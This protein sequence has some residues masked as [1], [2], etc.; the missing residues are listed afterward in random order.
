MIYSQLPEFIIAREKYSMPLGLLYLSAYLQYNSKHK[1]EVLDCSKEDSASVLKIRDFLSFYKPDLIGIT[2]YTVNWIDMIS[3]AKLIKDILPQIHVVLGGVHA[4]MFPRE[5]LSFSCIDSVI[6]GEGEE[7]LLELCDALEEKADLSGI[8]GLITKDKIDID[9]SDETRLIENLDSLPFPDRS[10]VIKLDKSYLKF[11]NSVKS[12]AFIISSRGCPFNCAFCSNFPKVYRLRSVKNIV[13]EMEECKHQGFNYLIFYDETFNIT[14]SRVIE[15]SEEILNRNL[16]I[17]WSFRARVNNIEE[18][19]LFLAKRAGC[20]AINY[21]VETST[22]EGLCILNKGI[23]IEEAKRAFYLTRKTRILSLAYFMIG[24]PHE[25]THNDIAKTINFARKLK[26]DYAIFSILTLFP[27]TKLYDLAVERG[28]F[29]DDIWKNFVL[30][31]FENFSPPVWE[32]SLSKK[33]LFTM[34]NK[35][36]KAFYL[37]PAR[38]IKRIFSRQFYNN[39]AN[40]IDFFVGM[41]RNQ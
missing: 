5:S 22:N 12:S 17:S 11:Q 26:P 30:N 35:A 6:L 16:N 23:T 19:M 1:V 10:S 8:K 24:C 31:P 25:K 34:L 3:L 18:K 27:D 38:S 36:Y 39:F 29:S 37:S 14:P 32:E 7:A 41:F 4:S 15:I 21:G 20:R 28:L 33:E 9:L 40:K 13:D 2:G